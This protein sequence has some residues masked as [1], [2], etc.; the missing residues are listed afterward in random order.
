MILSGTK[1][2]K[3]DGSGDSGWHRQSG[4]IWYGVS[5]DS[6]EVVESRAICIHCD[7]RWP[8]HG[9]LPTHQSYGGCE[10]VSLIGDGARDGAVM[11]LSV[12]SSMPNEMARFRPLLRS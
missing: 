8:G 5:G 10:S 2:V 3:E 1:P 7:R 6:V 4:E 12:I 11:R 9:P